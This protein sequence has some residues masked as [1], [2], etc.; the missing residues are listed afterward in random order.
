MTK[1]AEAAPP[2][3]KVER[4]P[5][6]VPSKTFSIPKFDTLKQEINKPKEEVESKQ[7]TEAQPAV[8]ARQKAFDLDQL[9]VAWKDYMTKMDAAGRHQETIILKEQF[10]LEG[11][12]ITLHIANEALVPSFEK[13]KAD[14]LT[15]LRNSLDNDKVTLKAKVVQVDQ[16]K[17][18]Y[19]DQE[20]FEH[21]KKK[22][23]ALKD[24]QEKLGLDPEF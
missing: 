24:L 17:M 15:A 18:L 4:K 23:P 11:T 22:Y 13:V 14:L 5:T 16:S 6:K 7:E 12:D 8:S 20:K 2:P 1:P 10:E 21:L 3:P 9:K 19:T